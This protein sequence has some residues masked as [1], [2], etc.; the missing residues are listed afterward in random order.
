MIALPKRSRPNINA[1]INIVPYIDVM[2]VLLVIFMM[3][4]PI[5]EQGMEVKLPEGPA[6]VLD[7]SDGPQPTVITIDSKNRYFINSLVEIN[8]ENTDDIEPVSLT[9]IV[10]QVVAR[11]NVYPD[12]AVVL[13]GDKSADYGILYSLMLQLK[14]NGVDKVSFSSENPN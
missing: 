3:T 13:R 14:A 1:D 12:M 8:N 11:M 9:V 6:N 10:N 5:I 4:T 2:L 7:Y